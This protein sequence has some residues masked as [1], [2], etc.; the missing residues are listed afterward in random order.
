MRRPR[1]IWCCWS[2]GKSY[3]ID[4]IG[5][6]S[7]CCCCCCSILRT[8][9]GPPRHPP[10]SLT[11]DAGMRC[12]CH[13]LQ[14]GNGLCCGFYGFVLKAFFARQCGTCSWQFCRRW[15]AGYPKVAAYTA[16]QSTSPGGCPC[17][18]KK[19]SAIKTV[20]K[21]LAGSQNLLTLTVQ[22]ILPTLA[23]NYR[24][25]L[26]LHG[27]ESPNCTSNLGGSITRKKSPAAM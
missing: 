20:G 13:Q 12:G 22:P 3:I 4:I 2:F 5:C 21:P 9:Q 11:Q 25:P 15:L 16:P 23:Y 26:V 10:Y 14:V 27:V 8:E 17:H 19:E 24:V 6:R 18:K 7:C 1:I